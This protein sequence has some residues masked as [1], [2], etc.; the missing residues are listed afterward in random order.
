[1]YSQT[2]KSIKVTVTPD[3][4]EEQSMPSDDY[5]IWEYNVH[6]AN[7]SSDTV[8]LLRRHWVVIDNKGSL[9]EVEGEGVVGLQPVLKPGEAFQYTSSVH[10]NA[11]SG[12]MMG[13][14]EMETA[15]GEVLE[16]E[17]PSFSLDC[18]FVKVVA[19]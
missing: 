19:N 11:P 2:T 12:V 6:I 8:Q 14:Y 15:D 18:P 5:F 3:Y 7:D 13:T 4:E 10:M 1:M 9:Q 16:V 17:I